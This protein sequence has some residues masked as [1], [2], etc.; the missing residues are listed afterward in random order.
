MAACEELVLHNIFILKSSVFD[1]VAEK[2]PNLKL[3]NIFVKVRDKLSE[4]NEIQAGNLPFGETIRPNGDLDEVKLFQKQKESL[5]TLINEEIHSSN[6]YWTCLYSQQ[7]G[8]IS[9]LESL[10][11]SDLIQ[12]IFPLHT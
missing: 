2:L 5:V 6:P 8:L 7:E 1:S 4:I 9:D 10:I 12:E 11:L 3:C